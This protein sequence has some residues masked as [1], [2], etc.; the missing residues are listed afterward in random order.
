MLKKKIKN[1]K[2]KNN[3]KF[4]FHVFL[5][6]RYVILGKM[7]NFGIF[8]KEIYVFLLG[9]KYTLCFI[10]FLYYLLY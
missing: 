7:Y 6:Y 5:I 4:L 3:Y 9:E 2:R 1:I 10:K 8:I